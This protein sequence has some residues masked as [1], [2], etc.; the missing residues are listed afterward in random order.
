MSALLSSELLKLRTTRVAW[1]YTIAVAALTALAAA[2]TVGSA[3]ELERFDPD[4]QPDLV[5]SAGTSGLLA[6]LLGI[7]LVTNEF[8]HGTITPSLLVTPSRSRLLAG[9]GLAA[10]LTGAA[11][12]VIALALVA[13]IAVPWLAALDVPL[14][15]TDGD[16]VANAAGVVLAAALWG[17]LGVAFGG[18][19]HS[20]V[21]ALIGALLWFLLGEPLVGALLG[22]VDLDGVAPYLPGAA[23]DA[24]AGGTTTEDALS[25]LGGT[26]V[27]LLYVSVLGALAIARTDRTD[28]T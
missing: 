21:G 28:V 25:R 22:L 16:V 6:L 5:T 18:V 20:Q 27:A 19:V 26:A 4:F 7:T 11:L 9:K 24:V 17:A 23:L 3:R 12:A 14:E 1:G 8:R 2:G 13:A 15:P 10:L